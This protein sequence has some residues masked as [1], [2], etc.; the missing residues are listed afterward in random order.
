VAGIEYWTHRQGEES[1]IMSIDWRLLLRIA[2]S[3]VGLLVGGVL[4]FFVFLVIV[5]AVAGPISSGDPGSG[6]YVVVFFGPL[7]TL[8]GGMVGAAVGATMVQ[9]GTTHTTSYK[10]ALLGA[11]I[12]SLI[13]FFGTVLG[14]AIASLQ[15]DPPETAEGI[16]VG[17][18]LCPN[19]GC[20]V[21]DGS[22]NCRWCGAAQD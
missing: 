19:C 7:A 1:G 6:G 3:F 18:H 12:G 20:R 10:R 17:K 13:P 22:K 9:E 4:A 21:A 8:L 11:L 16:P 5:G 14:A 2:G 15:T